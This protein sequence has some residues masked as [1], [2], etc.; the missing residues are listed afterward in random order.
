MVVAWGDNYYGQC[1]LPAGLSNVVAISA[2]ADVSLALQ[3][4]GTIVG[5]GYNA[6][7]QLDVPEELTSAMWLGVGDQHC[8]AVL[9]D[10]AP[11]IA[12]SPYYQT[13]FTGRPATFSVAVFG[14]SPL[15]YQ[16]QF[17]GTNMTGASNALFTLESAAFNSAG[18]YRVIVSNTLGVATSLVAGL[19]VE[20][21]A[22][23]MVDQPLSTACNLGGSAEMRVVADGSGPLRYQWYFEEDA[24]PGAT[25]DV[26]VFSNVNTNQAGNYWVTVSNS[27]GGTFSSFAQLLIDVTF[28]EALDAPGLAWFVAVGA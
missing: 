5:W 25:N 9:N 8:L 7:A 20:A 27:L 10:G 12:R 23:F 3:A 4:D 19:T 11:F 17:N 28:T 15:S 6:Y 18:N 13:V 2:R 21:S 14:Q 1:S 26:L 22:P 16:W 24:I